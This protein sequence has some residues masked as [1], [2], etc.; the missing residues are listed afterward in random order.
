M[1][2]YKPLPIHDIYYNYAMNGRFYPKCTTM[3]CCYRVVFRIPI[4]ESVFFTVFRP[5]K[6][7]IFNSLQIQ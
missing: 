4:E 1:T 6:K 5:L 3:M 7:N 2:R